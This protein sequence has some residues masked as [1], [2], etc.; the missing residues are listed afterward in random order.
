M[1]LD[2]LSMSNLTGVN[3]N[4]SSQQLS[5]EADVVARQGTDDEIVDMDG[6][7]RKQKAGRK[8]PDA[9]FNGRMVLIKDK[10]DD[11]DGEDAEQNEDNKKE[12][13]EQKNENPSDEELSK[14]N[15]RFNA[16]GM[17]EICEGDRV[18]STISPEDAAMA[19]KN[20]S[21]ISGALVNKN[22]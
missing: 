8:D 12:K 13:N 11:D 6:V 2:G 4:K 1:G 14:Y 10:T 17:I 20:M 5:Q 7:S 16:G 9:A 22:I 18:V 19:L 21:G 15:F 3:R